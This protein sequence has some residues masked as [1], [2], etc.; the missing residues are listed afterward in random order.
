MHATRR[1]TQRLSFFSMKPPLPFL[2]VLLLACLGAIHA[3]DTPPQ[4]ATINKA[5]TPSAKKTQPDFTNMGADAQVAY[6]V[7]KRKAAAADPL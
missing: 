3:A 7:Q 1:N 4:P 6:L 2:A 5:A